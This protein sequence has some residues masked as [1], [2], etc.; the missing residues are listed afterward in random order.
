MKLR[1]SMGDVEKSGDGERWLGI[2]F[3][4]IPAKDVDHPA[5]QRAIRKWDESAAEEIPVDRA[6]AQP[7]TGEPAG[8]STD[9]EPRFRAAAGEAKLSL[10]GC[11]NCGSRMS[12]GGNFREYHC[13]ECGDLL[14]PY[15]RWIA[16]RRPT[17]EEV[18]GEPL[19]SEAVSW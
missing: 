11:E 15:A 12:P 2:V 14:G 19:T 8:D 10:W 13:E 4:E 6:P 1:V 18:E 7:E 9:G 17:D 5:A 3:V 16:D